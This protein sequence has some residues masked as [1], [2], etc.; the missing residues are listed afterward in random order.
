MDKEQL[1]GYLVSVPLPWD[2]HGQL[3]VDPF[4]AATRKLLEEGCDGIYLFGT[5]GEGYA[6][7]DDEFKVISTS[8]RWRPRDSTGLSR[9]DVSVSARTRLGCAA[10]WRRT[11]GS[12]RCRL[13]CRS[14]RSSA[15]AS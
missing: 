6:V 2:E 5:S 8:S 10:T 4:R 9:S 14:G 11:G 1:R 12:P 13:P 7:S 15:M 3:L